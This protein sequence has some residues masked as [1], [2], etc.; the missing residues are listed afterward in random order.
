MFENNKIVVGQKFTPI[1]EKFNEKMSTEKVFVKGGEATV[2]KIEDGKVVHEFSLKLSGGG[3]VSGTKV[4]PVGEWFDWFKP[5]E[6]EV[7]RK[8]MCIGTK[9][10][11]LVKSFD[12]ESRSVK[13]ASRTSSG[14]FDWDLNY[15][16]DLVVGNFGVVVP[17]APSALGMEV[18][19][20]CKNLRSGVYYKVTRIDFEGEVVHFDWYDDSVT[21]VMDAL[22]KSIIR[23]MHLSQFFGENPV[24]VSDG[25]G[26]IVDGEVTGERLGNVSVDF[27][28]VIGGI[29]SVD[30]GLSEEKLIRAGEWLG[31]SSEIDK[32]IG[33]A[34]DLV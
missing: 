22:G 19:K 23:F 33:L 9:I 12:F 17:E 7:G 30:S 28:P 16:F 2:K 3:W 26:L 6:M 21:N 32:V 20:T 11:Y 5:E 15:P 18:G 34:K 14:E 25:V 13:L 1:V 24:A 10:S 29:M 4:M 27:E 8:Y 31:L